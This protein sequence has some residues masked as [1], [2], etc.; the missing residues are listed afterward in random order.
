LSAS[1]RQTDSGWRLSKGKSKRKID[2]C[3]AMVMALDR[4]TAPQ[5]AEA[6]VGIAE[7]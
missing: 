3:I 5:V 7:W 2:A 1:Q 4:A 6:D